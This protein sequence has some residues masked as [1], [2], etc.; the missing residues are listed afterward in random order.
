MKVLVTDTET[1]GLPFFNEPSEDPKQP[2]ICEVAAIL[3]DDVTKEVE[4]FLN[5]IVEQNGWEVDPKAFD[6][7]GITKEA[8]MENGVDER[9]AVRGFFELANLADVIVAHNWQFDGRIFRIAIKRF[10]DG[11]SYNDGEG[12]RQYIEYSQEQ[13]DVMADKLK[14]RLS[15]C[16]MKNATPILNLPATEAMVKAGR[17]K[18]KKSPSLMETYKHF[19]GQEFEGAHGALA[20]AKACA[21]IYFKMTQDH[22]IGFLP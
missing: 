11:L 15:Y 14:A 7:H 10:G 5:V 20:D 22:D 4:G 21:R 6:A 1:S 16:T 8:S 18:W 13:K 19:F 17:G 9:D 2:H 3:F 12:N